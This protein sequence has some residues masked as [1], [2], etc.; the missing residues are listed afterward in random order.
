MVKIKFD[1]TL[2]QKMLK[3]KLTEQ[4][5][6]WRVLNDYEL[7]I[8]DSDREKTAQILSELFYYLDLKPMIIEQL[9]KKFYYYDIDEMNNILT[10]AAQML[11]TNNYKDVALLSDLRATIK[12][13]FKLDKDQILFNY[14]E[15]K[16][17][18]LN[19]AG[20]LID[21]VTICAI[22]EKKQDEQYQIFLQSIRDYLK[23]RAR[24][25]ICYV[26]W[27]KYN[28]SICDKHGDFY[29]EQELEKKL[30]E[31]PIHIYQFSHNEHKVSPFLALN[32]QQILI[33][34]D[35]EADPVLASLENIFDERLIIIRNHPFPFEYH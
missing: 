6:V 17:K 35:D 8:L 4:Q 3:E 16:E 1:H 15:Q 30:L 32:P 10:Y 9:I 20:W 33:Y 14:D 25:P 7:E 18:F 22:D 26:K 19:Q 21:E 13:Y 31:T 23:T 12:Q 28:V 11:L 34:P 24:G 27:T 2:D 29:S 5:L